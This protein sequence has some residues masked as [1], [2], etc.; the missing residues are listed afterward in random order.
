MECKTTSTEAWLP[1]ENSLADEP[2]REFGVPA[3][4]GGMSV[5]RK[6]CRSAPALGGG[7]FC[8]LKPGLRT[9]QRASAFTLPEVLVASGLALV[10]VLALVL[11]SIFASRSFA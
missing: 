5:L 9:M 1:R 10:V 6:S 7:N 11:L 2:C 3:L 8:R 4:A